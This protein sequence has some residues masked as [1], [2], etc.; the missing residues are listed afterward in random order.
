[1]RLLRSSV[2]VMSLCLILGATVAS[3]EEPRS[4]AAGR[5]T[6]G[7][8]RIVD[9]IGA[10]LKAIWENEAGDIDPLGRHSPG[11][12]TPD[13]ASPSTDEGWQIDPLG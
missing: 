3:A 6:V 5:E 12:G 9:Q 8:A 7:M 4:A 11:T 2:V 1:M 10:F 13:P